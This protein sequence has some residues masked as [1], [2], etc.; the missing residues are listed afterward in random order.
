MKKI[1]AALALVPIAM[2]AFAADP[3][4]IL[5]ARVTGNLVTHYLDGDDSLEDSGVALPGKDIF[6]AEYKDENA[7]AYIAVQGQLAKDYSTTKASDSPLSVYDYYGWMKFGDL[8]VS[9]GE[10]E[11]RYASRVTGDLSS[12]GGLFD[13]YYGP[14]K[15]DAKK[16]GFINNAYES[17]NLTPWN[18][19]FALDYSFENGVASVATG[20]DKGDPYNA[21]EFFAARIGYKVADRANL[22]ATVSMRGKDMMAIGA[23]AEILGVDKLSL[24]VGYSGF[25]NADDD[26][27]NLNAGEL[28]ARY[29]VSDAIS[30]TTHNNVTLG[31]DS[32]I[33]Y[34]MVNLAYKLNDVAT[35]AFMLANTN[36]SGDAH[37]DDVNGNLVTVRPGVTLSP[38]KGAT[39]DAGCKLEYWKPGEGSG[40]TRVSIPVVFRVKF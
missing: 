27:Q 2:A 20:N 1:I 35:P 38:R 6:G 8:K 30:V 11:H 13:L 25:R 36:V 31:E 19:E 34:D 28:R 15:L 9:A 22:D 12:F 23:F 26:A 4:V 16:E 39:I 33:L 37:T 10:W 7:G 14:M 3:K 17:D 32:M 18:A 40:F 5:Q 24:V 29:A 21:A